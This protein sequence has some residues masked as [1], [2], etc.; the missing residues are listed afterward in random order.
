M[1]MKQMQNFYFSK[2]SIE[3]LSTD[4]SFCRLI[5]KNNFFGGVLL[6]SGRKWK[7]LMEKK[8]DKRS[9]FFIMRTGCGETVVQPEGHV[10]I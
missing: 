7:K 4:S 3:T 6:I 8:M 5:Q 9:I 2:E 1:S 10:Q